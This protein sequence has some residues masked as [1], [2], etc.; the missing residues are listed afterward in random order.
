MDRILEMATF[1]AVADG[2]SF[3]AAAKKLGL[4]PPTVTRTVSALE[5]RLGARLL[6]RT[7]RSVRLTEAGQR[8]LE[9]ARRILVEISEAEQVAA[10]ASTIA[11]GALRMTAP[12]L[13]GEMFVLPVM[14]EFLSAH[15]QVVA[16]LMLVDRVINIVEEGIDI[17]LR[18][19]RFDDSNLQSIELGKVRRVL[20][21]SPRYLA[22]F[23]APQQPADLHAHRVV[24]AVGSNASQ[25]WSFGEGDASS[26]LRIA[27]SLT[28]STL[29]AAI[30]SA[31]AGWAITRVLSY[32]VQDALRDGQ[33]QS[34]LEAFEPAPLP[35]CLVFPHSRRPSA[36]LMAFID[37]ASDRLAS[38]LAS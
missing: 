18:I 7:T 30:D 31:R 22:E 27:P 3:S 8:F 34:V 26:S 37:L 24:R 12:V 19:G 38:A 11:S 23:G 5:H 35:V 16:Q 21:A 13:F 1:V 2:H 28:V 10:G 36:K 14:R 17:A 29:R 33:L 25:D 15:P 32:Q 4:S 9:D 20:V 6:T